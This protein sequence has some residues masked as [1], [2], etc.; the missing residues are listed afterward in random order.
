M[1]SYDP[2][3]GLADPSGET[4][5]GSGGGG[6]GGGGTGGQDS[7]PAGE[8]ARANPF[9]FEGHYYDSAVK[10][11][12]M[13]ARPYLPQAGRFL[14]EDRY[15][16]AAGDLSLEA[17]ALTQD[18]YSF[19]GGNPV[20]NIEFDGHVYC[21]DN[22]VLADCR[23]RARREQRTGNT[24]P[25]GG[26]GREALEKDVAPQGRQKTNDDMG[27]TEPDVERTTYSS[28]E[29]KN[30]KTTEFRNGARKTETQARPPRKD[31]NLGGGGGFCGG[32]VGGAICDAGEAV[33][34]FGSA[35]GNELADTASGT[36]DTVSKCNRF[37]GDPDSAYCDRAFSLPALSELE[38][39]YLR[40]DPA[41]AGGRTLVGA[42]GIVTFRGRPAT[43]AGA[44]SLDDL[45]RAAA[46]PARG[47]QTAAGRALQEHGDRA[48]SSYPRVT[49]PAERSRFGQDI[50]DDYL[51]HPQARERVRRDGTRMFELPDGRG[52]R[53][54]PMGAFV[55][56]WSLDRELLGQDRGCWA[57]ARLVRRDRVRR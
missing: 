31:N 49:S 48:G 46:S 27:D 21:G 39:H 37:T 11:Y 36:Y 14:T 20:N 55:V 41:E 2:Y 53:S 32:S 45:S 38:E 9:R 50:V 33:G 30:V 51:T 13:Q 34:R 18:R 12:D 3:G 4:G 5:G 1:S 44:A 8:D 29:T 42:L 56:S 22:A 23:R 57:Q 28:T 40:G 16:S 26:V 6:T 15:E 52:S 43:K 47:G 19:A 17:D 10:T 25:N 54:T 24:T 35:A 7:E